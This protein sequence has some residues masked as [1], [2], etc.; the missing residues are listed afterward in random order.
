MQMASTGQTATVLVLESFGEPLRPRE[1]GIP[2]V[3]PGAVLVEIV[4]AGICGS[5]LDIAGGKDPRIRLPVVLGHEGVGRVV[6]V[7]G[8]RADVFGRPLREGDLVTWNRGLSCGH[9]R[10]CAVKKQPALCPNRRVYG[11]TIAADEAPGLNGCYAS[12]IYLRPATDIIK[13]PEGVD[14]AAVVAATCSGATAAHAIE[15]AGVEIGDVVVIL[16]PGP[17]G[18]FAAALA[19][20]RGARAVVVEG[21]SR[22]PERLALAEE[23]GCLPLN[24]HETTREERRAVID[25]VADGHGADVVVDAAGTRESFAEAMAIVGRGGRVVVPGV[26]TPIGGVELRLY[27]DLVLRNICVTGTWVSDTR[28]LWQAVSVVL[29]GRYPLGDMVTYTAAVTRANEAMEAVARRE[30]IK[31]VLVAG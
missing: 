5:D 31:A 7:G 3:G 26:A 9:C 10:M 22:S 13:L 18:L 21:T 15:Q 27:E 11:I 12:H 6:S 17:L 30:A 14:A 20:E 25:E 2:E 24:I 23:M 8:E 19:M 29:S 4:A 16:G 28:H 1:V